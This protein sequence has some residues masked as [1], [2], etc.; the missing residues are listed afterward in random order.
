MTTIAPVTPGKTPVMRKSL[1]I[2]AFGSLMVVMTIGWALMI[3]T[4]F[5][6][7]ALCGAVIATALV[8][9]AFVDALLEWLAPDRNVLRAYGRTPTRLECQ[10]HAKQG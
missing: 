4:S 9:R 5:I 8:C 7:Y 1:L 3:V 10:G 6:V 2:A